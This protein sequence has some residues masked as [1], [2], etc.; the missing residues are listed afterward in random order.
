MIEITNLT[1]EYIVGDTKAFALKNVSC[2]IANNSFVSI[3]GESGSGKSTLLHIIG[4]VDFAT[5][6]TVI[7][8]DFIVD[9]KSP[10]IFG[11]RNQ[12]VGFV[13]Q[14][15]LLEY[16]YSV[17]K[18]VE[19]PLIIAGIARAKRRARV[20]QS[21]ESVGLAG[22]E[23]RVAGTLSGGERQRV[24]IARAIVTGAKLLL[25]DEPCGNLDT[26]TGNRIM[27][28]ISGIAKSDITVILVTHN[29]KHAKMADRIIGLRDGEIISDEDNRYI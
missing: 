3:T 6:G 17:Y 5:S 27:A 25:A 26:E 1:K 12:E 10:K 11:Y 4:G 19:I 18:N 21:L 28:L 13:Y 22:K 20:L 9:L 14:S 8:D 23:K 2:S 15:F 29:Q 24:A 16:S 7:V